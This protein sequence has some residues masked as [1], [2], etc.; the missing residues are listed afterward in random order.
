MHAL[1]FGTKRAFHATLRIL[2][3]PLKTLG[4]TS[5]RFDLLWILQRSCDA[6]ARQ[7]KLRKELGVTAPTVSRMVKSLEAL[8]IVRTERDWYDRRQRIVR[9]TREGLARIRAAIECFMRGRIPRKILDRAFGHNG[10]RGKSRA[11]VIFLRMCEYEELLRRIRDMC[12]DTARL[13]YDWHPD[14]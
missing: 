2:R 11:E 5:A 7:S 10:E 6:S 3:K 9:L 12:G 8:G 13:H 4:L 14:D 1:F